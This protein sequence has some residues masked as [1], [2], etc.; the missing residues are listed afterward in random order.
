MV[1]TTLAINAGSSSVKVSVYKAGET[2]EA[3]LHIADAQI[4]GLTAPP[5]T[6]TYERD[7]EEI[8]KLEVKDV[9]SQGDAFEYLLN[10]LVDEQ[11]PHRDCRQREHHTCLSP[12]GTWRRLP[13][14]PCG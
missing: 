8:I 4:A 13:R 2:G 12:H 9:N 10:H 6:L 14:G 5:A 11:G 1:K 7:S 3:P